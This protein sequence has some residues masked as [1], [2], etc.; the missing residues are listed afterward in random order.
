[1][2]APDRTLDDGRRHFRV[3]DPDEPVD[4]DVLPGQ[5]AP[6]DVVGG[7]HHLDRHSAEVGVEDAGTEEERLTGLEAVLGE[8]GHECQRS[9]SGEP[10]RQFEEQVGGRRPFPG[11]LPV[12]TLH[13]CVDRPIRI[14]GK[15]SGHDVGPGDRAPLPERR[16]QV[17]GQAEGGRHPDRLV[18]RAKA[19]QRPERRHGDHQFGL[20]TGVPKRPFRRI[21]G[22]VRIVLGGKTGLGGRPVRM[23]LDRQWCVGGEE[24]HEVRQGAVPQS[25]GRT[26]LGGRVCGDYG[27]ERLGPGASVH[28]RRQRGVCPVPELGLGPAR[29]LEAP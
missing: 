29:G 9:I 8:Q 6:Q 27:V 20:G 24:L 14:A 17:V 18:D 25:G 15:G 22:N 3:D 28:G 5:P 26:K 7:G 4:V 10:D 1:M 11:D 12:A 23:C 19:A 16:H 13:Q 2:D 21:E